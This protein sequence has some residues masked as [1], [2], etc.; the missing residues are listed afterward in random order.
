MYQVSYKMVVDLLRYYLH[1]IYALDKHKGTSVVKVQRL[2]DLNQE[3][4]GLMEQLKVDG[5][6]PD[7]I[8]REIKQSLEKQY[9]YRKIEV[10]I[11]GAARN[12]DNV[13]VPNVSGIGF[14]IYGDSQ[15]LHE[16]AVY[17][18]DKIPLPRLRNEQGDVE[19]DVVDITNNVAEYLALIESL[20]YLFQEELSANHIEIYSDSDLIVNQV[21]MTNSARSP[22]M[23]RLRNCAQQLLDEFDNITVTQIPREDNEYVDTLLNKVLDEAERLKNKQGTA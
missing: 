11:D 21:N 20:E 13:E 1:K 4:Q 8:I 19:T 3:V 9:R 16:H 18:G 14:A 6:N 10:Y 15:L 17:L 12:N 2:Y 5:Y 7:L 23:I 22:R